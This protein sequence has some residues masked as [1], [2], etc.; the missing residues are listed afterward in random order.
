MAKRR[1]TAEE[2][3]ARLVQGAQAAVGRYVDGIRNTDVN[4]MERASQKASKAA[5]GYADSI[6]SGRWQRGLMS[7]T[8]EEWVAGAT[9]GGGSAY[10]SGIQAKQGKIARK[11]GPALDATYNVADRVANMPTDTVQ[12]RIA[13]SVA[14]QQQRYE[15][16]RGGKTGGMR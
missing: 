1:L 8:K 12:Q 16:S 15:A 14:Y 10:T 13:K 5:A 2:A 7:A 9:A 4:P 11:L 3:T 6:A